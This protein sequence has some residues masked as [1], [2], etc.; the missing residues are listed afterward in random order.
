MVRT[1]VIRLDLSRQS[2][3][4]SQQLSSLVISLAWVSEVISLHSIIA[5]YGTI[6]PQDMQQSWAF[7]QAQALWHKQT[8]CQLKYALHQECEQRCWN[9]SLHDQPNIIKSDTG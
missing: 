2:G 5:H 4:F 3:Q 8:F 7:W 6:G 9:G 1:G